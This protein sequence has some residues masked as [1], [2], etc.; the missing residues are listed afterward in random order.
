MIYQMTK[1]TEA[2]NRCKRT[3]RQ[4]AFSIKLFSITFHEFYSTNLINS[5]AFSKNVNFSQFHI[6][7]QVLMPTKR[8]LYSEKWNLLF[9]YLLYFGKKCKNVQ[10][11]LA[12]YNI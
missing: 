9:G 6:S 1:T 2:T 4:K 8:N 12:S 3:R 7:H 5:I 10:F 11:A